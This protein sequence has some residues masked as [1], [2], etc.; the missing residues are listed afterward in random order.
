[1]TRG[2]VARYAMATNETML[3]VR[4]GNNHV[5]ADNASEAKATFA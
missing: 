4:R 2:H 3:K 5:Y 1:M